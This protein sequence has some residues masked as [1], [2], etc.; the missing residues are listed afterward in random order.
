MATNRTR[1][2]GYNCKG[3]PSAS[4]YGNG[5]RCLGCRSAWNQYNKEKTEKKR[6]P[7]RQKHAPLQDAY[8][9]EQILEAR[10]QH[11]SI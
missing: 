2:P 11:E 1:R 9:R 3:K 6:G 7:R 5:C 10:A 4:C 8:T